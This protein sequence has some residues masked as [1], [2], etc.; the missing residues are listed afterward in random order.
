MFHMNSAGMVKIVPLASE[1]EADPIVCDRLASRIVPRARNSRK[2]A[3][4]ITAAGI[5]AETVR[6]T[7]RPRYAFAAP[8]MMPSTTPATTALAVNSESV[9]S[10]A[11]E[12]VAMTG[13]YLF[14]RQLVVRRLEHA[15]QR[16]ARVD[17]DDVLES[18]QRGCLGDLFLR[19]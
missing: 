17:L 13:V 10:A 14:L 18:L 2:S 7:L 6:P 9:P 3:T 12:A 4:V 8:S 5:D 16:Q 11:R 19:L 15:G 1:V